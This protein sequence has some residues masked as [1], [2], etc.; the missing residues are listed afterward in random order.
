MGLRLAQHS[1]RSKI[2]AMKLNFSLQ[3]CPLWCKTISGAISRGC[4]TLEGPQAQCLL[5]FQKH[6]LA[7]VA[8]YLIG[9]R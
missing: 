3:D 6:I 9:L 8:C 5:P 4:S 2:I 1:F 7:S